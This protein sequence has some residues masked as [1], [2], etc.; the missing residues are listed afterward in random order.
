MGNKRGRGRMLRLGLALC[1]SLGAGAPGWADDWRRLD[2]S[3]I[4]AALTDRVLLFDGA[5]TQKFNASGRTLYDNGQP[6]WGYWRVQG[7][8]YCSQWPPG[9]DWSC[10]DVEA[11]ETGVRFLDGYGNVST[12]T[13]PE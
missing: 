12:G 3:G 2:G 9:Q 10:Y 4:T 5:A 13:Y 11:S 7:D 6:S 1:L 8:Q